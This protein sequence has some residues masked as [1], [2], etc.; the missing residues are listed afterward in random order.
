MDFSVLCGARVSILNDDDEKEQFTFWSTNWPDSVALERKFLTIKYVAEVLGDEAVESLHNCFRSMNRWQNQE[1][2]RV[3]V[4]I[5]GELSLYCQVW[6]EGK[7]EASFVMGC[8]FHPVRRYEDSRFVGY[9]PKGSWS[10][11]S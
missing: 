3:I 6:K 7:D 8:V 9:E 4:S 11:H 10:M 2:V 5:D 1:G